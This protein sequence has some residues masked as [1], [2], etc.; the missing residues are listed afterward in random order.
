MSD[1]RSA[2]AVGPDPP[3]AR[4]AAPSRDESGADTGLVAA[5]ITKSYD[6]GRARLNVL[7]N[8]AL[9]VQRGE[10]VAIMGKSGSGKSTLLHVLGALDTA[11]R[12]EVWF[13]G[14]PILVGGEGRAQ[15]GSRFDHALRV[16][17]RALT[18]VLFALFLGL[19]LG[20]PVFL[21]LL[22]LVMDRSPLFVRTL[23][24][25]ITG[26]VGLMLASVVLLVLVLCVRLAVRHLLERRRFSSRRSDFG[27]VFQFYHLL[28]ELNVLDNVMLP[29]RVG[30]S[31]IGWLWARRAA[32][33]DA[34]EMLKRV[35][36]GERLRHRPSELSG[37]ERQRVALARA[38]IHRPR[39]LFAD[40][41]TG[42]LDAEAG[43]N[44]MRILADLHHDGQTIVMVTHDPGVA[45]YAD[46]TLRLEAGRL[47]AP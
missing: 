21:L 11:D 43:A 40:E 38:L 24:Y 10:F 32:R 13:E 12:G 29:R 47:T 3:R 37:G 36:L 14:R 17:Q 34:I 44:I 1:V 4:G 23:F 9:R 19:L 25:A 28:P 35:G 46:R 7:Q 2:R 5:G 41:P 39:V 20:F 45:R 15:A 31:V 22:P 8:C 33:R 18:L 42:N 27:F 26:A 6:M 16:A 30:A